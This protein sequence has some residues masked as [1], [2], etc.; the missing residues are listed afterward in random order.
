M[1]LIS[2][3]LRFGRRKLHTIVSRDTIKPSSPTPFHSKTYK[4]SLLDQIA[5]NSYVP[6]VAIYPSSNAYQ[7]SHKKTLQLKNSLSKVLTDY[8]PFAGRMKKIG[9]TFVDCNDE[10]VEFIEACNTNT[11]SDFLQQSVH[12]DLDQ[13]FPDDRI[14]FKKNIKN[15]IDDENI[16]VCPLSVQVSHFACGGLAIAT[17]LRHKI[18]DGSSALNFIKHWAALTSHS[19]ECNINV[20]SPI[21]NPQFIS[22]QPTTIELPKTDP[23]IPPNDVVSKTFVFSNTKIKDLQAKV[24]A[25]TMDTRQP[26]VNPTRAEVVSWFLHK[27]VSRNVTQ[28]SV[29]SPI[30]LRNKLKEKLSETSIGNLFYPITFPISN[31]HGDVMPDEFISKLRREKVKFQNIRN[32]ECALGTVEE[33]ISETFIL[34]TAQSMDTSYVYSSICG[35]PMYDIDFRWGKPVKVAVGGAF[36]NLSILMDAPDGNGIEVLVSLNKQDMNIVVN[37]PDLLAFC[38]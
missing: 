30:N 8:Y 13:L 11:L 18:G 25:M 19:R 4:L 9:P 22:Y 16:N 27:C 1:V 6:I 33:M 20:T 2:K 15:F 21:I 26:I 28:T 12:E 36:K 38:Y 14:W 5:V 10:G 37:D 3:V 7:S 23:Y 32:L 35:F 17:S 24:V 29:I 31:N 34:G